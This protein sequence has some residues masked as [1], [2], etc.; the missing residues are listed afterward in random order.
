[1]SVSGLALVSRWL[2]DAD[3]G[4][5]PRP[6]LRFWAGSA[7]AG[8]LAGAAFGGVGPA[9]AIGL[10]GLVGPPAALYFRRGRRDARLVA[11]LPDALDRLAADLRGG[12]AVLAALEVLSAGPGPLAADLRRLTARAAAGTVLAESIAAWAAERPL[13]AVAAV[14]G[15]L[16]VAA[17]V[18]GRSAAALEGLA[19]GLRDQRDIREEIAALSSQARLSAL[20]VALAPLGSLG[21][22]LAVDPRVMTTLTGTGPGRACLAVGLGFELVA[23]V[24]MHRLVR[25]TGAGI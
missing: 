8:G 1:M 19:G 16:E 24:W 17:A 9:I 11:E 20:V 12:G 25:V 23:W 2:A 21:L 22:S 7:S 10:A 18:G 6:A 13:P 5:A 3:I 14:A 4:L 15:A